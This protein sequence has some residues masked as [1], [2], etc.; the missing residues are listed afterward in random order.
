MTHYDK[1]IG[2]L[3][4]VR[5]DMEAA[6]NGVIVDALAPFA[7]D[8]YYPEEITIRMLEVRECGQGPQNKH[9]L[10]GVGVTL[11]G[12]SVNRK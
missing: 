10:G 6:L 11:A 2:E 12:V 4:N 9:V 1:T 8:E 5:S 3:R 7:R